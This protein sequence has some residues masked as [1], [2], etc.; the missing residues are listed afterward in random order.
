[1]CILKFINTFLLER[2]RNHSG[3]RGIMLG[4]HSGIILSCKSKV[5]VYTGILF[6]L[7]KYPILQKSVKNV[8]LTFRF[9]AKNS[10][11]VER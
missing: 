2:Y 1:M 5:L 3:I 7:E 9:K 11:R 6:L 4:Y 10:Q 8:N